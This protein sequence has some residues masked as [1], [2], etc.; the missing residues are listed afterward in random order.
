[1]LFFASG[2]LGEGNAA[3]ARFI[4]YGKGLMALGTEVKFYLVA[5]T[6]FNN[7]GVNSRTEGTVNGVPFQYLGGSV[8][9]SSSLLANGWSRIKSWLKG[10]A[11]LHKNSRKDTVLYFYSPQLFTTLPVLLW[12][13][14][15][16]YKV[17]I[18]LSELHSLGSGKA[19]GF[20]NR[21]SQMSHRVVE[22]H[23]NGL[24]DHLHVA[25]KRLKRY[26]G[27]RYPHLS[28]SIMPIVFDPQRFRSLPALNRTNRLGYIGSFG[29]KDGV[30]GIIEAFAKARKQWP[31]LKLRLIGYQ[32]SSFD[33]DGVLQSCG[34]KQDD[35]NLEIT[36][37]VLS[38]DIP[39]LLAECDTLLQ[40]RKGSP[41]AN[42][43][44]PI[45]LA[46]YMATGR[47][48]IS[49]DV[50]DISADMERGKDLVAIEPDDSAQLHQ[51]I[52]ER[53][54]AYEHH[55]EMGDKGHKKAV[56]LYAYPQHTKRLNLRAARLM[57][58]SH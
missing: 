39:R 1:M 22:Q 2:D 34:L 54:R 43:G 14:I 10:I 26:H 38:A 11:V 42:Y 16:Q 23:L 9:K 29:E 17:I 37:Q 28:K 4:C 7:T 52:L 51:A 8:T 44:F 3:N 53:Y 49:T 27:L 57:G 35:P 55:E 31:S 12:A 15:L 56:E 13:R 19:T 32:T 33:L 24:C 45:K 25:T 58:A 5:P 50:S 18:E 20:K 41:Y 21:L 46:E 30:V 48:V 6:E 47:P 36:G 40:N